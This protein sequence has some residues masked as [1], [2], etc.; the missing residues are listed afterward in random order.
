MASSCK[1]YNAAMSA[2][3]R[4]EIYA[5]SHQLSKLSRTG[6]TVAHCASTSAGGR[7]DG[8]VQAVR[9]FSPLQALPCKPNMISF[10]TAMAGSCGE[11]GAGY[12]VRILELTRQRASEEDTGST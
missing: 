2:V 6:A 8:S 11:L 4:E 5:R 3:G 9:P 7:G 12:S 1:G 10:N